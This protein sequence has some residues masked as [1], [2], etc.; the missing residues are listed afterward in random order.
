MRASSTDLG[1]TTRQQFS[2]HI[3]NI[4]NNPSAMRELSNGRTAFWDDVTGTVVIRNPSA[5]D[6]GTAFRPTAGKSYFTDILK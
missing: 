2:G 3:E 4:M 5:V 1:I 6:G